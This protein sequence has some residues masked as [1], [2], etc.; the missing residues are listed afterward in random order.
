RGR[1]AGASVTGAGGAIRAAITGSGRTE[2]RHIAIPR[3]SG[4]ATATAP[5]SS[6]AINAAGA[7]RYVP[8]VQAKTIDA[9]RSAASTTPPA[10][11]SAPVTVIAGNPRSSNEPC[12]ESLNHYDRRS[13]EL[14]TGESQR[15][16]A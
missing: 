16:A 15:F 5:T 8:Q 3:P 2:V 6:K 4:A 1:G 10:T 12:R 7:G 9:N 13:Q 14:S 11:K